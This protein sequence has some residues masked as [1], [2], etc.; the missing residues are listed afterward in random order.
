M[1]FMRTYHKRCQP[2]CITRIGRWF[3]KQRRLVINYRF[4]RE[5]GHPRKVALQKAENTIY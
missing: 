1:K 5:L 2:N 4:Y 3:I